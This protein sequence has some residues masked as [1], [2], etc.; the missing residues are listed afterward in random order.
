MPLGAGAE[1]GD[2]AVLVEPH[3]EAAQSRGRETARC[4]LLRTLQ[5]R[6]TEKA[7]WPDL[8]WRGHQRTRRGDRVVR[9]PPPW[10]KKCS[11]PVV[12]VRQG[13]RQPAHGADIGHYPCDAF[14]VYPSPF[15]P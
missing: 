1:S 6:R 13:H 10:E 5:Q 7:V 2:T 4:D 14:V 11:P 8:Q 3:A 15:Y 9:H 12:R